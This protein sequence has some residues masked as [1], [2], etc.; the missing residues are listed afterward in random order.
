MGGKDE[1]V[2]PKHGTWI[3]EAFKR[4]KVEHKLIIIPGA[5][6]GLGGDDN[7]ATTLREVIT[8]FDTHLKPGK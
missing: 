2:P 5:G 7:R 8:W 4:E 6:H 3:A 1:L